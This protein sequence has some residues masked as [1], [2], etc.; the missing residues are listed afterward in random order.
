[1]AQL[2]KYEPVP[3][4]GAGTFGL[5]TALHLSRAGHADITLLDSSALLPLANS[6]G[7][8]L[9]KIVRAEYAAAILRRGSLGGH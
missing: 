5:S 4:L 9:N 1:M 3:I 2:N 8:D 6:A 7:N